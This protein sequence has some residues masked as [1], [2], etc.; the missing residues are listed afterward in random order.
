M[1]LVRPR[2][3]EPDPSFPLLYTGVESAFTAGFDLVCPKCHRVL[4]QLGQDFDRPGRVFVCRACKRVAEDPVVRVQ[5]LH[6]AREFES[7][8]VEP[9]RIHAYH[10]TLLAARAVEL[11][12]LTCL[13]L[14]SVMFDARVGL[15]TREFLNLQARREHARLERHRTP[16]AAAVLSFKHEGTAHPIF[17]SWSAQDLRQLGRS[18]A[19]SM[20]SLDL[21][22]QLDPAR[23]GILLP[24]T[25]AHGLAGAR[26][27][28]VARLDDYVLRTPASQALQIAWTEIVFGDAATPLAQVLGFFDREPDRVLARD[29]DHSPSGAAS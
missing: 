19:E 3:R 23:L 15:A 6:C 29:Q 24:E 8:V 28:L 26:E 18:I 13:D 14:S 9:L 21:V 17:R 11:N 22:A 2:P 25:D 4:N 27:R 1:R 7:K 16:F 12:R 5:C 20:R 10:P